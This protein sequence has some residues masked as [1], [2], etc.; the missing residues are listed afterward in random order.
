MSLDTR[1][2]CDVYAALSY[3]NA[4][5][6]DDVKA[7]FAQKI[8]QNCIKL[9]TLLKRSDVIGKQEF[10]FGLLIRKIR[11]NHSRPT[12][13]MIWSLGIWKLVLMV[14]ISIDTGGS[15]GPRTYVIALRP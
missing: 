15:S 3:A 10:H 4:G 1:D 8:G 12:G 5:A 11:I 2:R 6:G 13:S 7:E 14:F 9:A